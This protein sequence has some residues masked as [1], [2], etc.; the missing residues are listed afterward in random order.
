MWGN[1]Q[2]MSARGF[3]HSFC[4]AVNGKLCQAAKPHL[5][6]LP[7]GRRVDEEVLTW[8]RNMA[9]HI[10]NFW[11]NWCLTAPAFTQKACVLK[12]ANESRKMCFFETKSVLITGCTTPLLVVLIQDLSRALPPPCACWW[13]SCGIFLL[14][15]PREPGFSSSGSQLHQVVF[16][17]NSF[18]PRAAKHTSSPQRQSLQTNTESTW[19]N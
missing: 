4:K 9:C 11:I 3:T 14:A 17:F 10:W 15:T 13:T 12:E 16:L 18:S 8:L 5:C 7:M 19:A 1:H 2:V 6:K